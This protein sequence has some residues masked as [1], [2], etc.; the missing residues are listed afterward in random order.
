ML[1]KQRICAGLPFAELHS[2]RLTMR[3]F[4]WAVAAI[5]ATGLSCTLTAETNDTDA[6]TA[7][8]A[9]AAEASAEA[10]PDR[11]DATDAAAEADAFDGRASCGL[12][13]Q[14]GCKSGAPLVVERNAVRL[15]VGNYDCSAASTAGVVRVK[16]CLMPPRDCSADGDVTYCAVVDL[17]SA[18]LA[19][20]TVPVDVTLD[21]TS[22]FV[23]PSPYVQEVEPRRVTYAP[24]SATPLVLRAWVEKGCFCTPTGPRASQTLTGTIHIEQVAGGHLVGRVAL[25]AQGTIS[26]TTWLDETVK[27]AASFDVP[28]TATPAADAGPDADAPLACVAPTDTIGA[29]PL[30]T[31]PATFD[32]NLDSFGCPFLFPPWL[33]RRTGTIDG[34]RVIELDYATSQLY[35]VYGG[36]GGMQL[37]G[38]AAYDDTAPYCDETA[39]S[40]RG[41]TIPDA[42]CV[43]PGP[44]GTC[45]ALTTLGACGVASPADAAAPADAATD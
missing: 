29:N 40:V 37:V 21:G 33:T 14:Q 17:D 5:A 4:W 24:T 11:P 41:G 3:H 31:C 16:A 22:S 27:V 7:I 13:F 43:E 8:D 30:R 9:D 23:Y 1:E 44:A 6:G 25:Q 36:D 15:D 18:V 26:P 10:G 20:S 28:I 42:L 34:Y 38:A 35:C 45:A 19:S 39:S 2:G 32:G 12:S